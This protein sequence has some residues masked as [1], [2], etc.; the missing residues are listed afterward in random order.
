[1]SK[2]IFISYKY[3]DSSVAPL[4]IATD[5][6]EDTQ[7]RHYVSC[8]EEEL[9][10][11]GHIYKGEKDDE[12][13]DHLK[14]E[15]IASKLRDKIFDSSITIVLISKGMKNLGEKES[16]QWIPW[17]IS[18][19]LKEMTKN[20]RT[21]KTNSMIAIALPDEND[22]Y[23][24]I[25]NHY[26]CVTVWK[27]NELFQILNINMFNR[28]NENTKTCNDCDGVHHIGKDHSYIFPIKWN[29]FIGN[30]EHYI[31]HA[32]SLNDDIDHFEITKKL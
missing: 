10:D 13:L 31:N 20:D 21:S 32:I 2:K 23:S 27:T 28:K 8:L 4:E 22:S 19:S 24:Y 30:K 15:T 17:E 12:P 14:D 9:K 1:M 3:A 6:D 7:G 29:D 25:V 16:N 5:K 11:L 18:Y 26:D